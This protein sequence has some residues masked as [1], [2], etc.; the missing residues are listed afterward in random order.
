MVLGETEILA[1]RNGNQ[2]NIMGPSIGIVKNARESFPTADS[3]LITSTNHHA[4]FDENQ[5]RNG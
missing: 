2:G 4:K 3:N 5:I 1:L